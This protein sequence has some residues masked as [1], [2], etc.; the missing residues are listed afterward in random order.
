MLA[1]VSRELPENYREIYTADQVQDA[2]RAMAGTLA[3][4]AEHVHRSTGEQPLALCV[5]R[6]AFLFFADLLKTIPRSIQPA[7]VRCQSYSTAEIL[8]PEDS[9]RLNLDDLE[10]V[11]R[12]ILLV[13]D[14][15]D[16]GRTLSVI[17]NRLLALGAAEVLTATLIHRVHPGSS[18]TPDYACFHYQGAEWFAGYGMDDRHWRMNYP[19]VYLVSGSNPGLAKN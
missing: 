6:G 5:L 15:C 3:P 7:F 17:K 16:T 18:F 9:V 19:S 12:H 2:V 11:G 10:A 8:R 14:I 4:W 13:D 1:A